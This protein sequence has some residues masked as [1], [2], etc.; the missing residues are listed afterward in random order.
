M[1]P[2][3]KV[4]AAGVPMVFLNYGNLHASQTDDASVLNVVARAMCSTRES[5]Y[6]VLDSRAAYA[7]P[8]LEGKFKQI[9]LDHE[10]AVLLLDQ[11]RGAGI[12]AGGA[13]QCLRITDG[14]KVQ[15]AFGAKGDGTKEGQRW[16]AFQTAFP[17]AIGYAALSLPAFSVSGE[18]AA[19][20]VLYSCGVTCGKGRVYLVH[21]TDRGWALTKELSLWDF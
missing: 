4:L 16:S 8:T 10:F 12:P 11:N 2:L 17:G 15:D 20:Y 21:R 7:S 19:V 18:S 13:Y 6:V 3:T 9:G 5:G 1:R 14:K